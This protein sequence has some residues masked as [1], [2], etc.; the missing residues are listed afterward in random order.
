M[1]ANSGQADTPSRVRCSS[2]DCTLVLLEDAVA[3]VVDREQIRVH[4]IAL[5]MARAPRLL[6]PNFH[7]LILRRGFQQATRIE[8]V[9]EMRTLVAPEC[10]F[11]C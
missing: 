10:C 11:T 4:G 6:E 9:C 2:S 5:S 3:R 8:K 1:V 7:G